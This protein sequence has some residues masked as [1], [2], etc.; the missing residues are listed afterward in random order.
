[1]DKKKLKKYLRYVVPAAVLLLY[2]FCCI[3]ISRADTISDSYNYNNSGSAYI[4]LAPPPPQP[5]RGS[6][7]GYIKSS[8][9]Y[10]YSGSSSGSNWQPANNSHTFSPSRSSASSYIGPARSN[11]QVTTQTVPTGG[12]SGTYLGPSSSTYSIRTTMV[13]V[14]NSGRSA[15]SY[16]APATNRITYSYKNYGEQTANHAYAP[17]VAYK[18]NY[19]YAGAGGQIRDSSASAILVPHG[20]LRYVPTDGPV[21]KSAQRTIYG[22]SIVPRQGMVFRGSADLNAAKASIRVSP[23]GKM[24]MV[25][26]GPNGLQSMNVSRI[27]RE[28]SRGDTPLPNSVKAG[29]YIA[30]SSDSSNWVAPVRRI[31]AYTG[32]ATDTSARAIRYM[33]SN[34][35]YNSSNYTPR[36]NSSIN[37]RMPLPRMP[38]SIRV[39]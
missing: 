37:I 35:N 31:N 2:L 22:E 20:S 21:P 23:A 25:V 17:A 27:Y 28:T 32:P 8:G 14:N 12:S 4:Y 11:Y 36:N 7:E 33:P 9:S 13:P 6:A 30:A 10:S 29:S 39:D 38:S 5:S 26:N 3:Q 24:T 18:T 16:I 15:A 34:T 19:S 1:M